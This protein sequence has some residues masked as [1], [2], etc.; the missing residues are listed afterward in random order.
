MKIM[1]LKTIHFLVVCILILIL[2]VLKEWDMLL[3]GDRVEGIVIETRKE[4]TGKESLIRGVEYRSIIGYRYKNRSYTIAGPENLVYETG[5]NV[6]LIVHPDKEGEVMIA[7][8]A[9]FYIHRRSIALIIV[10]ILWIAIFTTIVQ[11]QRGTL[12]SRK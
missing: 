8:L 9:G 12:Y 3:N 2:P 4:I 10:L 11:V 5:K 6:P 1:R 7:S